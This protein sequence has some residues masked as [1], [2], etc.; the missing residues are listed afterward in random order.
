MIDIKKYKNFAKIQLQNRWQVPVLMTLIIGLI[1][2]LFSLPSDIH[3]L[4]ELTSG[5]FSQAENLSFSQLMQL[6]TDSSSGKNTFIDFILSL[7]E[8]CVQFILTY[9]ALHVYLAM[10]RSPEQIPFSNFFEGLSNWSRG[11]LTGLYLLLRVF[12]WG[13]IAIPVVS[14]FIVFLTI[15]NS[16]LSGEMIAT[17]ST[18]VLL[19]GMIPAFI[20]AY[21]YSQTFYLAAEYQN[22]KIT[23]ALKLSIKLTDGHKMDVFMASLTF[24]GWFILGTITLGI[25]NLLITPYYRMAMTNVYHSLLKEAL[26]NEKIK[27][28]DLKQEWNENQEMDS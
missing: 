16:N 4:K 15:T 10:S 22:I 5:A 20:K 25:A 24:I 7:I 21:A 13:L 27:P 1:L 11:L 6:F 8:L 19:L 12:L 14:L 23:D 2:R 3:M 17:L 28:E 18:I 26:E 9:G